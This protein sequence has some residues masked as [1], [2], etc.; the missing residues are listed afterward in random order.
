MICNDHSRL[1]GV[2]RMNFY[3]Y[4]RKLMAVGLSAIMISTIPSMLLAESKV[5]SFNGWSEK[6]L[7]QGY[8][9]GS[10]QLNRELTRAEFAMIIYRLF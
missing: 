2:K 9:D 6:Q 8:E 7:L 4:Q 10:M 1:V 3:R 5:S